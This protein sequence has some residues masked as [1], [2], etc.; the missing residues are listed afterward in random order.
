VF[1]SLHSGN[2]LFLRPLNAHAADR[3]GD[4]RL[5]HIANLQTLQLRHPHLGIGREN[6][7]QRVHR[8]AA[9]GG[10][11]VSAEQAAS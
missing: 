3:A 10:D 2:C 5:R 8:V 9:F 11:P 7:G 1:V 6:H 4:I